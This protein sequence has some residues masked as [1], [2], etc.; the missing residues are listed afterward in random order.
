MSGASGRMTTKPSICNWLMFYK[1][2][3][4]ARNVNCLTL[5]DLLCVN[6]LTEGEE[7]CSD[8]KAEVSREH[9]T[10]D[11]SNRKKI[12]LHV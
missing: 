5:G 6:G 4:Y 12:F 9:S 2:G 11:Y 1:S 8:R 7:I 3:A 10:G